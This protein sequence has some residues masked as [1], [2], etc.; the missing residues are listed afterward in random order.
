MGL[1][2]LYHGCAQLIYSLK[3]PST[4]HWFTCVPKLWESYTLKSIDRDYISAFFKLRL[5]I[6]QWQPR[7]KQY[8]YEK[9][10]YLRALFA[11]SGL[12]LSARQNYLP[13]SNN[14]WFSCDSWRPNLRG[15]KVNR[16]DCRRLLCLP[17]HSPLLL[18]FCTCLQ[19]RSVRVLIWKSCV[20]RL[21]K[22]GASFLCCLSSFFFFVRRCRAR[23]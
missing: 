9:E 14:Y 23:A 18:V 8:R 15:G 21:R 17:H 11:F 16:I 20:F 1:T 4:V 19:F 6:E 5:L 7:L 13:N 10:A 3:L 2:G 22:Q 12:V